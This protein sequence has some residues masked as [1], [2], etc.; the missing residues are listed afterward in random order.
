MTPTDRSWIEVSR[1]ALRHNFTQ[2]Q[3]LVGRRVGI[4]PI[5]KANGYGHG[6]D[7]I[8][9]VLRGLQ[10][11]IYG[12]AHGDEALSLRQRGFRGALVVL[13]SW[14]P[15]EFRALVKNNVQLSVW[16]ED[17]LRHVTRSRGLRPK[18]HLKVDTGTTRVGFLPKQIEQVQHQLQESGVNVVGLFSHFAN[19]EELPTMRTKN[20]L[21]RFTTLVNEYPLKRGITPHIACTAAAIRYPEAYFG[22]IRLGIGLYGIWPSPEIKAWAKANRPTLSLKPALAWKTRLVQVKK[23]PRGTA[24]GYGSTYVAKRAMTVG[25]LPIGYFDGFDR[26]LS[27]TGQ[28]LHGQTSLPVLGRVCMNLTMVD[29]SRVSAKS[30]DVVTLIGRGMPVDT[31]ATKLD[32]I[33]YEVLSRLGAHLPRYLI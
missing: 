33:P 4:M 26:G 3:R 7:L 13:S 20:Q 19:A 11:K 17:S 10:P 1:Q 16:D 27:N 18:V 21:H 28:V 8:I 29:C 22:L 12:V 5:I 15:H 2:F 24:V 14:Q 25:V 6:D 32:T 23:V 9:Q 30:G 31:M